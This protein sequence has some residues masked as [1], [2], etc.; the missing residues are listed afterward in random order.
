MEDGATRAHEAS[1]VSEWLECQRYERDL[2]VSGVCM[3]CVNLSDVHEA[4]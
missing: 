3:S 2:Y 1:G 4:T